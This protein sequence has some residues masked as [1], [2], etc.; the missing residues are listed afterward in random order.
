MSDANMQMVM[1]YDIN[2][3]EKASLVKQI[4]TKNHVK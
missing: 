4:P 1:N 3:S 2:D